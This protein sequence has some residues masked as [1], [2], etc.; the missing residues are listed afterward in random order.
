MF[1]SSSCCWPCSSFLT[2]GSKEQN[3]SKCMFWWKPAQ[4]H[5]VSVPTLLWH[6]HWVLCREQAPRLSV[7]LLCKP[8]PRLRSRAF[9]AESHI[10]SLT[11]GPCVCLHHD[12]RQVE[13]LAQICL[14]TLC[15]SFTHCS[16]FVH[17]CCCCY[18]KRLFIWNVH[19]GLRW[20]KF[21]SN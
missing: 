18:W 15:I 2:Y 10:M 21:F 9:Q 20:V 6:T 13:Y 16:G 14:L 19:E 7:C 3:G 1:D 17:C 12:L 8:L 4:C 5:T 11:A